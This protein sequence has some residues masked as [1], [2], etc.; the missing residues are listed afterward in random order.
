MDEPSKQLWRKQR[1][2]STNDYAPRHRHF[3]DQI[4]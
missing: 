3:H 2:E 4:N 1:K